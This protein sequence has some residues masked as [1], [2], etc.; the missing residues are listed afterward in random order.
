[1]WFIF[2]LTTTLAWGFA[3]LFYKKGANEAEAFTHLKTSVA[4]G[5]VMGLHAVFTLITADVGYN[6]VNLL[7]YLPVSAMYIG[8]MTVGYFGL[9]YL[10]LSIS[11]P[12]QNSSGAVTCIMC[13]LILG[14]TLDALSGAGVVM[15]CL[16]VFV[17]GLLEKKGQ[18]YDLTDTKHSKGLKAF[19]M[20]VL[21]C[22]ID[23]LGTFFDAY[24][25]DD[26][27]S[28]PLVGVNA[29]NLENVA[30]IS[31]ELTF[32]IIAIVLFVYVRFIKKESFG[33]NMQKPRIA[34]AVLETAGQS[35]YVFAMSG[36]SAAAAPMIA[37]YSII[38]LLLSAIFLKE[39]L[40]KSQYAAV[41]VVIAGIALLGV[42]EGL[43][44]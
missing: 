31:Y 43:A 35:T 19:M 12:I 23:A 34:A 13:L 20:P 3:D 10:E 25:L 37:S 27:D 26:V 14:Q 24:Y 39:K 21:Y 4:V 8:S 42:A 1:M 18:T 38:S 40:R 36:N 7:V 15:I 6:P 22:I 30:N 5:A 11:S 2:A 29:D 9:R 28:T 44:E 16:G 32:L 41:A 17:L 33:F